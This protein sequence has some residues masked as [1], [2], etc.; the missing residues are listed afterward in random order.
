MTIGVNDAIKDTPES[1][2]A[3]LKVVIEWLR[4]VFH[5]TDSHLTTLTPSL[6]FPDIDNIL[7]EMQLLT[8]LSFHKSIHVFRPYFLLS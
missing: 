8:S 7:H 5:P 2:Q 6:P 3:N 4:V 1:E